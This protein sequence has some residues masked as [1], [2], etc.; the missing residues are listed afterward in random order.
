VGVG[1]FDDEPDHQDL[2]FEDLELEDDEVVFAVEE[3]GPLEK[4]ELSDYEQEM[5]AMEKDY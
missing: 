3:E 2:D 5:E 4:Y 1:L